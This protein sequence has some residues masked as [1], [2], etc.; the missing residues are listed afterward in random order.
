M[1]HY[2]QQS[3]FGNE[4][5]ILKLGEACVPSEVLPENPAEIVP[6]VSPRSGD[7]R[8]KDLVQRKSRC[9]ELHLCNFNTS[10]I[11]NLP[12]ERACYGTPAKVELCAMH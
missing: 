12:G 5:R 11:S 10:G 7:C 3:S 4:S 1:S 8:G 2:L 6:C 9:S